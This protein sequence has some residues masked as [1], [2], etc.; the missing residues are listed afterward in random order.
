MEVV[1]TILSFTCAVMELL[2]PKAA[3][4]LAVAPVIIIHISTCAVM[5]LL[6]PKAAALLAA[7]PVIIIHISTSAAVD[8]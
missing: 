1:H 5:E 3:A 7:A 6:G 8:R 4:L 2:G